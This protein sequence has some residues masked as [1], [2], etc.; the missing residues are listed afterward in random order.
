MLCKGCFPKACLLKEHPAIDPACQSKAFQGHLSVT[1][2]LVTHFTLCEHSVA[3]FD[4]R[5]PE[6]QWPHFCQSRKG[7]IGR[8]QIAKV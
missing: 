7:L 3:A 5:V 6:V 1:Q 2:Q 4:F 8:L